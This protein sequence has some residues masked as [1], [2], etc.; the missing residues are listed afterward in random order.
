[1]HLRG[2]VRQKYCIGALLDREALGRAQVECHRS[3]IDLEL[4]VAL[5]DFRP[6]R[7]TR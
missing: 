4:T 6:H 2:G 1:M 3:G 7:A 5:H